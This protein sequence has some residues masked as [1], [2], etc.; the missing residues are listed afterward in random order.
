MF[1]DILQVLLSSVLSLSI[2]ID[3]ETILDFLEID[4]PFN[5][6]PDLYAASQISTPIS[7]ETFK[8]II[9]AFWQHYQHGLGFVDIENIA[10]FILVLR[11]IFLSR[12]YNIQTGFIITAIGLSAGYVWFTH[13]RDLAFYYMKSTW[14]C[15]LTHNLAYDFNEI[16][17]QKIGQF[18]RVGT[19]FDSNTFYGP[20]IR[21]FID[22]TN[23]GNYRY[24]PFSM[25]W[26]YLPTNVK[27]LSDKI[28]Y[29]LTLK[30][31]PQTYRVISSVITRNSSIFLYTFI[32]RINKKYCPYLLR[33]HWTF[34]ITLDYFE[35]PFI[36]LHER[37]LYYLENI[38]IP[39]GYFRECQLVTTMIVTLIAAQYIFII[40]G[41]LHA[42]CGQYFYLPFLT[43][44]TEVHVGLR[45]KDSIY[46][47]GHT[48]WQNKRA[49][50]IS[51][52]ASSK[53]GKYRSGTIRS[54]YSFLPRLWYG[55]LGRGNLD[56]LTTHEYEQ[57]L[58]DKENKESL[59]KA[60]RRNSKIRWY[61]RQE[62]LKKR[63][64]QILAKFGIKLDNK[65][66]DENN[67]DPYEEFKKFSKK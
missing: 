16:Y 55:W 26:S 47:G 49:Y 51:R 6:E 46:S 42:L 60:E 14:M 65:N 45:P 33:W 36:A 39:N 21:G 31:I 32:T 58:K 1:I 59:K 11:F 61:Y 48:I 23:N 67:D 13:L 63:F 9:R 22:I 54:A 2:I 5:T 8:L 35:R 25:L 37:L 56:D 43:E 24:D 10:I 27:F 12:K 66:I 44:T 17:L 34:L 7:S 40:L 18:Q 3:Q 57:Y 29:F 28:Y 50:M 62:R 41:L 64:I 15:S 19:Q 53:L 4:A 30:A 38:L 52:Q 20:I